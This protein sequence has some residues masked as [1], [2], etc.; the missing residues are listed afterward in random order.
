MYCD[1][2][3]LTGSISTWQAFACEENNAALLHFVTTGPVE[4]EAVE[5]KKLMF[6]SAGFDIL[7]K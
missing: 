3:N 5:S 4:L 2:R 1:I 6:T 7:Q